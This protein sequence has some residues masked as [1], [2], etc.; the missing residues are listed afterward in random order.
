M[1]LSITTFS[2]M[3]LSIQD[4]ISMLSI[5]DTHHTVISMLS[6][7]DTHHTVIA[8]LSINDTQHT[9]FNR[10]TQQKC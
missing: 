5:N 1:T 6:I 2:L 4:L 10:N 9:G 8:M 7:N 3:T